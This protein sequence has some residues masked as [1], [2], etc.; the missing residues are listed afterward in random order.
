[1]RA[2]LLPVE[3]VALPPDAREG[4]RLQEARAGELVPVLPDRARERAGRKGGLRALRA[5]SGAEGAL[6]VVPSDHGLRRPLLGGLDRLVDWPEKVKLMQRNWIGRRSAPTS[7]FPA[8][9]GRGAD[10]GLH[11]ASRHALRRDVPR[12]RAPIIPRTEELLAGA[13]GGRCSRRSARSW[14]GAEHPSPRARSRKR[15]KEGRFT[16][17][18]RSTRR[19]DERIPIWL[20]NYVLPDYGTGMIMAVPAHDQ[21]GLRIRAGPTGFRSCPSS[22]AMTRASR[23]ATP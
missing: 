21:T 6:A 5:D 11:D 2:E 1:M 4:A 15:A 22:A 9:G 8:R 18:S 14:K 16:G 13:A 12:G 20:A 7:R 23:P 3:P 19:T 10:H 17:R